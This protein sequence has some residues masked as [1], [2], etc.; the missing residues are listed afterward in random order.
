MRRLP[1][2]LLLDTST[3]MY[4]EPIVAVRNGVDALLSSLRQEPNALE[5]AFLSVIEFS[6]SAK[7]SVRLT[8]LISFQ[9]PE[10]KAEGLTAMGAALTLLNSC[11]D[12]EVFKTTAERRGD[13]RPLVFLLT[14]GVATDDLEKGIESLNKSKLGLIVACAAGPHSDTVQLK[15]ITDNVVQLD[16]LDS[17]G[18]AAF[19][20]WVS[21][22]VA[23]SST[24]IDLV[25]KDISDL[26][27]LP[28][29]PKEVQIID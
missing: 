20:K 28:P 1:I 19:F 14:D 8:E 24:K 18:I 25:K 12:A 3:S 10:I 23:V 13:W 11:V 29:P 17:A 22:S 2:Y 15:K 26:D 27:E 7:Q 21:D 5:T 6:S 16:T 9:V 4:G